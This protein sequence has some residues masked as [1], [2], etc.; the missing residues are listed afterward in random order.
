MRV[1]MIGGSGFIGTHVTNQLLE[2]GHE[3]INFH[4]GQTLGSTNP[5]IEHIFGDRTQLASFRPQIEA[6]LPDVVID[7]T[8]M[9]ENDAEQLMGA[10][11][12]LGSKVIVI[13]SAD[14]YRRYDSIRGI[15]ESPIEAGLMTEDSPL[16]ENLFR[17][18]DQATDP[19]DR[20]YNYEK[21]LVERLVVSRSQSAVILRLP[22]VYG[23]G[24]TRHRLYHY[25]KRMD[26]GRDAILLEQNQLR[27]RWTRGYVENVAAA[28]CCVTG[29]QSAVNGIY[30]VGE[31]QA[32][33][34]IDLIRSVADVVGWTGRIIGA[35][36]SGLP[37]NLRSGLHWEHQL[38]TDTTS[39]R[40]NFG[41]EEVIPFETG[42]RRTVEWERANPP[43]KVDFDYEVEDRVL[44][45][46]G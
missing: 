4:R 38:E 27:W 2:S 16:R 41:F 40:S 33:T 28:I 12:G 7:M 1:L 29:D 14:V 26:D 15:G 19:S 18:R 11:K 6:A 22:W 3:V 31:R 36:P 44:A 20:L 34:E 13:S 9:T 21:I 43:D 23:P 37:K 24:D 25:I 46:L 10:V 17:H 30:N 42:L 5:R 32:L 8:A 39:L 45:L 35:D